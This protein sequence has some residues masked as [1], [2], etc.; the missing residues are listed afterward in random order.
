MHS[1]E[2]CLDA[3]DDLSDI[4]ARPA[5]THAMLDALQDLGARTERRVDTLTGDVAR[6]QATADSLTTP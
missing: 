2:V 1:V 4:R 6:V 3:P 5:S